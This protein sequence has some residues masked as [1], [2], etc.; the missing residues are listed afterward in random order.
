MPN[1]IIKESIC[2][3]DNLDR[4][5]AEEEC[6]FYRLMV[7]CDDFGRYDGRPAIIKGSCF[8]LKEHITTAKLAKMLD[9]LMAADLVYVYVV[10]GLPYVQMT[11]WEHHQQ[12]RAK[13]SK[14]PAPDING[15]QLQSSDCKCPRNPIQSE[16]NPNLNP[17][18]LCET[19]SSKDFAEFWQH[20][21]AMNRHT[22]KVKTQKAWGTT[23]KGRPGE[24]GHPPIA[25]SV[26]IEAANHYRM[27]C[28]MDA[29][30]PKYIKQP[31]T[32]LGPDRHWEDYKDVPKPSGN[33]SLRRVVTRP[34]EYAD[35][36]ETCKGTE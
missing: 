16:S 11:K 34:G 21:K 29:T 15:N 32:F 12:I 25:P 9:A 19:D 33:G 14:Y 1:R 18:Q 26:L 36:F 5:T 7:Q 13:R 28:E 3:S 30:E 4:L 23:L 10:C 17:I 31:A 22:E 35:A 24:K 20:F 2:R 6:F 8:P 27:K